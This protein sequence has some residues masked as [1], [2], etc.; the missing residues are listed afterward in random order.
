LRENNFFK[1]NIEIAFLQDCED[2]GVDEFNQG[3]NWMSVILASS[4]GFMGTRGF[5]ED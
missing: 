4:I 3:S 1:K 2:Q 5:P